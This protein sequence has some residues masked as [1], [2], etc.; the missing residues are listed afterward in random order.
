MLMPIFHEHNKQVKAL[1]EKEY[2]AATHTRY[3]TSLNH[4]LNFMK[5]KYKIE[6]IHIEGVN[7]EEILHLIST[8]V[9]KRNAITILL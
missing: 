4:V 8:C 6:D 3:E 5:W 7:H 2:A 9:P 1:V